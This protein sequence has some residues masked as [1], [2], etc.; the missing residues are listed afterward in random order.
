MVRLM[1]KSLLNSLLLMPHSE[2][3]GS[4]FRLMVLQSKSKTILVC[5][6][7]Y[8]KYDDC[9]NY[10]NASFSIRWFE[11]IDLFSLRKQ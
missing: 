1:V 2:A 9:E 10:Y 4:I 11:M 3:L 6:V 7:T 5:T 8:V